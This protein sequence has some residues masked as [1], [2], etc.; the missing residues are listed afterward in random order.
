METTTIIT[1]IAETVAIVGAICGLGAYI[2]RLIRSN[3]LHRK[4]VEDLAEAVRADH[5]KV[6]NLPCEANTARLDVLSAQ[7][8]ALNQAVVAIGLSQSRSPISPTEK[9]WEAIRTLDLEGMV[10]RNWE[11]ISADLA[12]VPQRP[13]PVQ[14][15]ATPGHGLSVELHHHGGPRPHRGLRL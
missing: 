6:G 10:G 15:R 7:C 1:A 2:N 12:T 3:A 13:Y 4:L 9:G 5:D 8:N 11:R 14:E